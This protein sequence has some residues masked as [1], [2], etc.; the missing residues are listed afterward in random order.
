MSRPLGAGAGEIRCIEC[1][2]TG[3]LDSAPRLRADQMHD[4]QGD[5]QNARVHLGT[6]RT[7]C[8]LSGLPSS[9]FLQRLLVRS[10]WRRWPR[11][12]AGA[13]AVSSAGLIVSTLL[14]SGI[15]ALRRTG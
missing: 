8:A 3:R 14:M 13:A 7:L 12:F 11:P 15:S 9:M 6:G 5:R 10:A 4:L 1:D 2:G